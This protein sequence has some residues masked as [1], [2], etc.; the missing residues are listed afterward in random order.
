MAPHT[1]HP[2]IS[3]PPSL[4]ESF[5]AESRIRARMERLFLPPRMVGSLDPQRVTPLTHPFL[6]NP[7]SR[8]QPHYRASL[9]ESFEAESA[10]VHA[11]QASLGESFEA[12]SAF[13]HTMERFFGAP[14]D[15][16]TIAIGGEPQPQPL[17]GE[18]RRVPV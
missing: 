9:K 1:L 17:G 13:V 6:S 8:P 3:P 18:L 11:M 12:E 10:F 15:T 4:G 2:S 7:L 16:V 5:E 14:E